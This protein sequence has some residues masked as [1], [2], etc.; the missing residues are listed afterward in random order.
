MNV[1][2][3]DLISRLEAVSKADKD[4]DAFLSLVNKL[5]AKC[6]AFATKLQKIQNYAE[7]LQQSQAGPGDGGPGNYGLRSE[8][9]I[10]REIGDAIHSILFLFED[11]E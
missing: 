5:D 8:T 10:M 3:R 6:I 11:V 2:E 1:Q 4:I 7:T 9:Q